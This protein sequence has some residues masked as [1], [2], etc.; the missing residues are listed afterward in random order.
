MPMV[1]PER[2]LLEYLDGEL[3]GHQVAGLERHLARCERCR[4]RVEQ[5]RLIKHR[6][7]SMAVPGQHSDLSHRILER[8]RLAAGQPDL[9]GSANRLGRYGTPEQWPDAA[10]QPLRYRGPGRR[11][12][13]EGHFVRPGRR[14]GVAVSSAL[15]AVTAATLAGAY[16]IGGEPSLAAGSANSVT[17][18]WSAI[19]DRQRLTLAGADIEA[20]RTEGWNCPEL[21]GMGFRLDSAR[22]V[23]I[24]GEPALELVLVNG[25][26]SVTI[27]E[28]RRSQ[29]AADPQRPPVNAVTAHSVTADGFERIGGTE[30]EMWAKPGS[31][32]QVVLDSDD[33]TYTITSSLPV[34]EMPRAV[35]GI[36]V[37][38]R[39]QLAGVPQPQPADPIQRIQRGLVEML[40]DG[41][42]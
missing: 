39:A 35:A 31:P 12:D 38:E 41:I 28:Q 34:S 18:G 2:H 10:R 29:P 33:V 37:T 36:V 7:R 4:K 5:H 32:W 15:V 40:P 17:S 14:A 9:H 30:L 21:K 3:P 8:T 42:G 19:M 26:K 13:R 6:L 20:L 22:A 11:Q 16:M 24:S 25:A 27:T 1:H 23:R